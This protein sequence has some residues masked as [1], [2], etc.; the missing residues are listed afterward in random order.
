MA[1]VGRLRNL[2]GT[3]MLMLG[4]AVLPLSAMASDPDA[5]TQA[6]QACG[7]D[8][9]CINQ[10]NAEFM[11]NCMGGQQ[12]AQSQA[13]SPPSAGVSEREIQQRIDACGMNIGCL[14]QL[15]QEIQAGM[16][17]PPSPPGPPPLPGGGGGEFTLP[18][19]EEA[20]RRIHEQTVLP[21]SWLQTYQ[22]ALVDCGTDRGCWSREVQGGVAYPQSY[23]GSDLTKGRTVT[24]Q[25]YSQLRN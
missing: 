1:D 23:C 18:D 24:V 9:S 25:G 2:A 3:A 21:P 10:V 4:L 6:I 11:G 13:S 8:T 19:P 22:N 17:Q 16:P 14:N 12:P 20:T 5:M 15:M 7:M